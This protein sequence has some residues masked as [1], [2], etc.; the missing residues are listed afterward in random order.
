M[1]RRRD[2]L[3]GI[4]SLLAALVVAAWAG[5]AAAQTIR[6]VSASDPTCGGQTPC[7]STIQAAINAAQAGDTVRIQPGAYIEQL[8]ITSKNSGATSESQRI[9]IEVAPSAPVGSVLLTPPTTQ[10]TNGHAVRFQQSKFITLR[11]LTITGAGGQAISL[12][13]GNNA[14]VAIQLE[15]LRIFDNGSSECNGGIT[16][17]RGNPDTVIANSLIYANGRSGITFIDADGGPHYVV[18][19]TIHGNAWNGLD[20]AREHVVWLVNNAVTGNG[21]ATGSTGGRFGVRRESST[22]PQPAGIHL[23]NNLVCGNRLGE[24]NGPMLDA[25]DSANR[26]PTG[27]EGQGVIATA[28]CDLASNVYANISGP[29]GTANTNDDDF[30][31]TTASPLLD[32]GVDPRTLGFNSALNPIFES[33]YLAAAGRPRRGT[34]GGSIIFDI[35]AREPDIADQIGPLV[36]I[37]APPEGAHV[38]GPVTI[39][40]QATDQGSGVASFTLRIGSQ[41]LTPTLTPSVPPPAPSVAA[42]ATWNTTAFTDG[43]YTLTAEATDAAGNDGMATRVLVADNTPPETSIDSGPNGQILVG[44]A[45][46]TFSGSDNQT[47]PPSLV[48]SWRIDGGAWS[49]FGGATSQTFNSL[50]EGPHTFEVKARDLAGNEDLTPAVRAFSVRLGPVITSITPNSGSV[51]TYITIAG[52]NFVPGATTVTV[53]GIS[54]VIRTISPTEITTTVP[55]GVSSGPVTVAVT[56][57]LGVATSTFTVALTGDF[58]LTALPAAPGAVTAIAGDQVAA[59]LNVGGTGTFTSLASLSVSTPPSGITASFSPQ[60]VAPGNGSFLTFAVA[61]SVAPATYTF[62]VTAQAQIDGHTETRTAQVA[63][64]VLPIDTQAV[65]GRVLSAEAAPKPIPGVTIALNNAETMSDAAGNFV[66]TGT[67]PDFPLPSGPNMLSVDGRTTSLPNTQFANLKVQINVSATGATR[68]PFNVY[69]PAIDTSHPINLPLDASGHTTQEVL[70]T[71]PLIPGLVITIPQNTKIETPGGITVTQITITPVPIDRSPVPFPPGVNLPAI[72]AIG[73]G[74]A[75]PSQP[76]PVK[77]P[78]LTDAAPGTQA[79]IYYFDFTIGNWNTWGTGTVSADGTQVVSDPGLGL[80]RLAWHGTCDTTCQVGDAGETPPAQN[81]PG[82]TA[83]D[84]VDLFTGRFVIRKTDLVLPGRVPIGIERVYWSGLSR[85]GFF[86]IGWN[87]A[88]DYD[89]RLATRGTSLVLIRP[90]QSQLLFA[91]DGSGKWVNTSAPFMQG[92]V[93]T[94]LPGDFIFQLRLK[95]GTLQRFDRIVGF[96]NVAALAQLTDRNANT[97]TITR[98]GSSPSNFGRITRLTEPAGRS[99]T[100]AYDASGRIQTV[101]DPI[102]RVVRY[103]YDGQGRLDTMTDPENGI[104]RYSYDAQHRLRT[105]TDPRNITYLTNEY[106]AQGRVIQQTQADGGVWT[107]GYTTNGPLVT[108]TRVIDPRSN[109]TTQRFSSQGFVISSTDALGQVTSHE[110]APGTN[111]RVAST[112]PLGRT[113]RFTYDARGNV[114]SITD[115]EGNTRSFLYDATFNQVTRI[116]TPLVPATQFA[117]DAQGNVRTITDPLGKDTTFTYT[118]FGQVETIRDPLGNTTSFTYDSHGNLASITDPLG[119]TRRFEYDAVGRR[120]RQIDQRGRTSTF[121]YD[122]LNRPRTITDTM[123][124]VTSLTYDANGN[125]LTVT[126]ARSNPPT[127]FTY[128]PMDRVATRTDPLGAIESFLY[129]LAGNL[130]TRTDRK[131]QASSFLYDARNRQTTASYADGSGTS[132]IYDAVSR[133]IRVEDSAGGTLTNTYDSMDRLVAQS[134]LLGTV[135]YAYDAL[136]RRTQLVTPGLPPTTYGYDA[137]S[138]LTHILRGTSTVD[139]EYDDAGRRTLLSLPNGMRTEYQYDPASHLT[140][141]VYRNGAA[142]LGD[143]TYHYDAAGNRTRIGGSFARTLLPDAIGTA[144]YD[145]ANRQHLFG[146]RQMSFDPNGN[147]TTVTEGGQTSSFTWDGRDRLA[148]IEQ[149][150]TVASFTYAFDRRLNKTT[151]GSAIQFLFDDFDIAQQVEVSGTTSYLRSASLDEALTLT[152]HDGTFF[153]ITDALGST[154]AVHDASGNVLTEYSY[155]PF[156]AASATTAFQ[157]P[158]Q[159]TGRENDALAGLHYFRARYYHP[160]LQR[161]I[162]EDPVGFGSGDTNLYAY[163]ENNPVRYVDPLGLDKQEGG[164]PRLP[165][166]VSVNIN[167][168]IPTPWTGTAIGWSGVVALDRHGQVFWSPIG[169]SVGKSVTGIAGSL[170]GGWLNQCTKP[171]AGQLENFLTQ[172]GFSAGG[173]YIGG[174]GIAYTPGAGTATQVGLYSPQIG[175]SYNYSWKWRDSPLKW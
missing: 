131:G 66:L 151:N 78:N 71:T 33:D 81:Q 57:G 115:P 165:D 13:G 61:S 90:D 11:G 134:T 120:I 80:P 48:F 97:V 27:S 68:L 123:G 14:N 59:R 70:A 91:P 52:G 31:P 121:A 133:L 32:H 117:Y 85:V 28:G 76:L 82:M 174:G 73:P 122:G 160:S 132:F 170:T 167:V 37:T 102:G 42:S 118:T 139:L 38:R 77:F 79:Q 129:D 130:K 148:R 172:H 58:T 141:R 3:A 93:I 142:Q 89:V 112:D 152:N 157:N 50:T 23:L 44:I 109:S 136:G 2:W 4:L 169:A 22:S 21:T 65:T 103:T 124:G 84:P 164:C 12:L 100:L 8:S 75:V 99:L 105:I 26:T 64:T 140:A 119:N 74:G 83:A 10:C 19:N 6:N 34:P 45:T 41:L 144:L 54:A 98:E 135:S 18:G 166:Y 104:T 7:Y 153:I 156:G 146:T 163:V 20:V 88:A 173:G 127:T 86:G 128:D 101:T 126:D 114:E 106:D 145:A 110:Y 171:N 159:Y 92:A 51:G 25:T 116:T 95:D 46:F 39:Q 63:L 9:V 53:G 1:I 29:D 147:L 137:G 30:T 96:A 162:S 16:I 87:L 161:F 155:D 69:L 55:L 175:A 149:P 108:E 125:L 94:Q 107:F 72:F 47:A 138:R 154:L 49:P 35:G 111:L 40:A 5:P 168:A 150:G 56:S 62:S 113:M 158:F 143:L 36:T 24:L 17:A 67:P 43:I 60:L 15:R